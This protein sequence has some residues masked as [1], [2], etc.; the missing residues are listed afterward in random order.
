MFAK[1]DCRGNLS[2]Y[3]VCRVDDILFTGTDSELT[4]VE[5]A[6]RT[7]RAGDTERLNPETPIVFNGPLIGKFLGGA[8]TLSQTQYARDLRKINLDKHAA[9]GKIFCAKELRTTLRQGLGAPI[10]L[11]QTRPDIGYDIA[12]LDTD[13]LADCDDALLARAAINLYN[14]TVRFANNYT[15]KITYSL[16][17]SRKESWRFHPVIA[18][19]PTSFAR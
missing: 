10:W 4:N 17:S 2:A 6:L 13:A 9:H 11:R 1:Y 12:K 7:F 14:K 19:S 15:R 8:I 16:S 5:N 18:T 3:L